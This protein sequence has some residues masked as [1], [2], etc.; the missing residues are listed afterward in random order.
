M[1][2]V[3]KTLAE[4][5][6]IDDNSLEAMEEPIDILW[7][8]D[9]DQINDFFVGPPS[10]EVADNDYSDESTV[11]RI[12]KETGVA[13]TND[14]VQHEDLVTPNSQAHTTEHYD[15]ASKERDKNAFRCGKIL[16]G[17]EGHFLSKK[18]PSHT[19]GGGV[20]IT[21]GH[22]MSYSDRIEEKVMNKVDLKNGSNS[23]EPFYKGCEYRCI[24]CGEIRGSVEH[25]RNHVRKSHK[26]LQHCDSTNWDMI[27]EEHFDCVICGAN[28]LRDYLVIKTHVKLRHKMG[29]VEYARDH[30]NKR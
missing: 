23:P 14:V 22:G 29:M 15:D 12:I 16:K 30:V 5:A 28:M 17:R 24:S 9:E 19:M 1:G 25:I 4:H 21:G 26:E 20:V 27:H 7:E 6:L 18:S 3:S 13:V 11:F 2:I 10:I 8:V